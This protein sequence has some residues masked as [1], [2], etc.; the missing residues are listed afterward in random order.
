MGGWGVGRNLIQSGV[1]QKRLQAFYEI[2]P[3]NPN[4][5]HLLF[6]VNA[7]D[8][9]WGMILWDS[10]TNLWYVTIQDATLGRYWSSYVSFNPDLRTA[11][12]IT[13]VVPTGSVPTFSSVHFSTGYWFDE[14][15]VQRVIGDP[16]A[17]TVWKSILVSPYSG[18]IYPTFLYGYSYGDTFDNRVQCVP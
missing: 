7:G 4:L 17:T 12:W 18:C 9:M 8:T 5:P 6:F 10:S 16:A 14:S 15:G 3:D 13:E 1:D 2:V 11:E